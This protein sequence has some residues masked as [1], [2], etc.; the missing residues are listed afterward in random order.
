MVGGWGELLGDGVG[1]RH[2][3]GGDFNMM[4][5]KMESKKDG[6]DDAAQTID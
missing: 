2:R 3:G 6:G 1:P 5:L 4:N